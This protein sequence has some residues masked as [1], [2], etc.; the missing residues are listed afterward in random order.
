[1]LA[2]ALALYRTVSRGLCLG[3]G[4]LVVLEIAGCTHRSGPGPLRQTALP[5]WTAELPGQPRPVAVTLPA[6]LDGLLPRAPSEYVLRTRVAVPEEMRGHALTLAVPHLPALAT[7]HADGIEAVS[8]S[9]TSLDRYRASTPHRWRIPDEAARDGVLDLELRVHHRFVRSAWIDGAPL[10]TTDADGGPALAAAFEF[11]TVAAIGAIAV[12]LVVAFLY[13]VLFVSLRDKRR[14]AYGWFA[15]GA[16]CGVP[17]PAFLLGISQPALGVY[18]AP[19]M[20]VAL[21]LGS[22]A[23]MF[24]ARAYVG[25]AAPRRVWFAVIAVVAV[26][27]VAARDP[28][29]S[30]LV[31]GPIVLVTTMANAAAQ[32]AFLAR[33]RREGAPLTASVVMLAMAWPA[34]VLLGLPDVLAWLGQGEATWGFRTASLGIM[35]ISLYQAAAL[36]REHLVALKRSDALNAELEER[37]TLLEAKRREVELLNDELRRQIAARSRELAEKLARMDEDDLVPP[38]ALVPGDVVEGRYRVLKELGT[39]GMG[40]VYEVERVT[41]RRH[42]ALKALVG[43]GTAE[44]RARFAREA[45]IV[46]NVSHPN[47]ISVV[48][49]DV[50]KSGFLFLVMELVESGTT[51]HDVRRRERDV[52]WTLGV[53]AQVAA[54]I[55]AVHGA[56]IIHRDLKPGNILF[57]RG[58]DGR[59]PL[60][61]ITD[62][63]ISSLVPDGTRISAME[64]IAMMASAGADDD[65]DPFSEGPEG[66]GSVKI[67]ELEAKRSAPPPPAS[68]VDS[69]I[70]TSARPELLAD[71]ERPLADDTAANA[72]TELLPDP[73]TKQETPAGPASGAPP[74]SRTPSAPLTETGLIFGTPQYM[75]QELTSGTKNATRASDV[76]S[77]GIIAF[78]MLTGRRPFPEAPVSA[79][80]SGRPLPL[81]MPFRAACP[82]LPPGIAALLDRALA[83]DPR[84][85]PTAHELAMALRRAAADAA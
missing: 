26:V 60:V 39:G 46:A 28:F 13:G 83:H 67:S 69:G 78:E 51:L 82:T 24:F 73:P 23:A 44:S 33:R 61:K 3:G 75:A 7:L 52:P 36:T 6:H 45:Q 84:L 35:G 2:A 38:P 22:T 58:A 9:A 34:T 80:L 47:V 16:V 50:A 5:G 79:K 42:F 53:L 4:L 64:R 31:M 25:A 74:R 30:V 11:N 41:D 49:V 40:T 37:V 71:L 63:G 57:S 70:M 1:V 85:R 20:L 66:M 77:L 59:K 68:G 62:F 8:V 17:Y 76:F 15:L 21:A 55:D 54:G 19:V 65:L 27:A 18:E 12:T 32:V 81:P 14:A 72:K 43:G 10:L 29:V 48:D 56:G